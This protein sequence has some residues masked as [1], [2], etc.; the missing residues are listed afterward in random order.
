MSQ[1]VA[2]TK[3][4]QLT[5]QQEKLVQGILSGLSNQEAYERAGYGSYSNA[6]N[7]IRSNSVQAALKAGRAAIIAG[8]MTNEAMAAMRDLLKPA[9]PS[10]T[11]LGAA[12]WVLEFNKG[13][14][15]DDDTPP[16]EMTGAQLDAFIARAEAAIAESAPIIDVTPKNGALR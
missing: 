14:A 1:G 16:S 11:R 4:G 12:K 13:H 2:V 9:T 7:A 15:N 3:G 5:D 10:A 8:E 6:T